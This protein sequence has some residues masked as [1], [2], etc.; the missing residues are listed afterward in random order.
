MMG[1]R[2]PNVDMPKDAA[3]QSTQMA[4]LSIVVPAYNEEASIGQVLKT[5]L[6]VDTESSGFTKEIIVVNDGSKD[7]TETVV[8]G[9]PQVQLFNQVPNQGRGAALKRGIRE[10]TGDYILFQDADLEYHPKDYP[11]MLA[12][13]KAGPAAV[14]GNRLS[15]VIRDHGRKLLLGKHPR[16]SVAPWAAA[17]VIRAWTSLL[18]GRWVPDMFTGIK[19]YPAKP[20][21]SLKLETTGFDLDHEITVKLYRLGVRFGEAPI[22]Y[23]PRSVEEGKKIRPLD[24]LI[25]LWVVFLYRFKPISDWLRPVPEN[26]IRAN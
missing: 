8:R 25:A 23:N 11:A 4:V 16:Q 22:S 26:T 5:I 24:G 6:E 19:L 13:L 17:L 3:L 1:V 12:V 14:Y 9:F 2:G 7:G 15:G 20:L 21:K 18:V 10:A